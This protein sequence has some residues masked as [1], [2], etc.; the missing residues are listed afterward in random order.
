MDGMPRLQAHAFLAPTSPPLCPERTWLS[1]AI[2]PRS[3]RISNASTRWSAC[4][5][6]VAAAAAA[7]CCCS[8]SD[9]AAAVAS[10]A[11]RALVAASSC[12]W[13]WEDGR[14]GRG[15]TRTEG[16]CMSG[17]VTAAATPLVPT[18]TATNALRLLLC[19]RPARG[20]AAA[21]RPYL[22]HSWAGEQCFV[23]LGC[24]QH[25]R[26][27]RHRSCCRLQLPHML[28]GCYKLLLHTQQLS[29]CPCSTP[30]SGILGVGHA[31]KCT[32]AAGMPPPPRPRPRA[33]RPR[34]HK[35]APPGSWQPP[36]Q[37]PGAPLL[38]LQPP[39][40]HHAVQLRALAP[41]LPGFA[42]GP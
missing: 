38:P 34:R 23:R 28:T 42:P 3:R 18:A 5:L 35:G 24:C 26:S 25:R 27:R 41:P 21:T 39:P 31:G 32:V 33:A 40:L 12:C 30:L 13:S 20:H 9:A 6:S 2:S 22:V 8:C 10:A 1:A 36:P 4:A 14:G 16:R 7:A 11:W 29:L 17:E 19:G 15:H 37:P